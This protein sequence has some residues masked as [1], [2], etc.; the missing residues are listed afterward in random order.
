MNI[1]HLEEIGAALC[2][3]ILQFS[4][5]EKLLGD[6]RGPQMS[7]HIGNKPEPYYSMLQHQHQHQLQH[8]HQ[9]DLEVQVELELDI[10]VEVEVEVEVDV[11]VGVGGR[12]KGHSNIKDELNRRR[13][14]RKLN[15]D[16]NNF[17]DQNSESFV[18]VLHQQEG[19]MDSMV[20]EK[21]RNVCSTLPSSISFSTSTSTAFST[22]HI[23][24]GDTSTD[25]V[26]YHYQSTKTGTYTFL[27][28]LLNLL[29]CSLLFS[30]ALSPYLT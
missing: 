21:G 22:L 19:L 12:I 1:G 8:L 15:C 5:F 28:Q 7:S 26:G 27:V 16:H 17:N 13:G 14:A 11:D 9:V 29:S 3:A 10:E 20:A 24:A 25:R 30:P 6:R 23:N 4:I 18:S 2:D